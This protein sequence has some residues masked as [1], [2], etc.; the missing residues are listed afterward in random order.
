MEEKEK[1]VE[2][3][4]ATHN[5]KAQ[6]YLMATAGLIALALFI[7]FLISVSG[8]KEVKEVE[9]VEQRSDLKAQELKSILGKGERPTQTAT[10]TTGTTA[11]SVPDAGGNSNPNPPPRRQ[12]PYSSDRKGATSSPNE[13][14]TPEK[15]RERF[16]LEELNR[17]LRA[18]YDKQQFSSNQGNVQGNA[19][20]SRSSFQPQS[21][22]DKVNNIN[23]EQSVLDAK[24]KE[25]EARSNNYRAGIP[26]KL[27]QARN[28]IQA[29]VNMTNASNA[30]PQNVVPSG[31]VGYGQD[32]NY[33]ASTEGMSKLP[34]GSVM[35]AITTMTAIS[36]YQGG[37]MKAML[38]NDL[39]DATNTYVLA[40]KGSEF[41]IK[42]VKASGVNEVIQNRLAFTVQWLV[43]PNGDRID[44]SKSAGLDRM[45]TPAVEG[46][47]VDR[48]ILAQILGVTAYAIV[49]S[50]SSYAGTGDGE[51]SMAGEIGSGL[52]GQARNIAAKYLQIV[53]T[54]T[55]HAG[56]PI[57]I[58]TEDEMFIYP[59]KNIYEENY[60]N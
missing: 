38:T 24:I 52:R 41:V 7:N 42:V 36:D 60:Y 20:A 45:G 21:N 40:P 10:G 32:N 3:K 25:M 16:E 28:N 22:R 53:P 33:Q 5:K 27:A 12:S 50:K 31:I 17:A 29:P 15:V 30:A 13:Q 8:K 6:V 26:D 46:D 19:Y 57:R 35:N 58:I 23:S 44:F 39:Y 4:P 9:T 54:V 14:N 2:E 37:T 56:A 55:L 59:W 1:K 11:G 48:H 43:L 34:V 51:D 18:R 49:G 47:E